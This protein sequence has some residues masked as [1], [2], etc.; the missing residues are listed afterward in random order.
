MPKV[1]SPLVL[2]QTPD[3]VLYIF[4]R[5]ESIDHMNSVTMLF[6]KFHVTLQH[7]LK[8]HHAFGFHT[9]IVRPFAAFDRIF[10]R[11]IDQKCEI[12]LDRNLDRPS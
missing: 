10:D 4:H 8:K 5:I 3:G 6:G 9:I 7:V 1:V 2:H 12:G 11:Y